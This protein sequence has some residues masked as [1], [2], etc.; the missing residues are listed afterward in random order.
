MIIWVDADAC[1]VPVKE[2]LF[3]AANRLKIDT[4]LV[5]NQYLRTPASQYISA[6]QVPGGFD[7]ADDYIEEQVTAGD[8]VITQDIPLAAKIVELGAVGLNPR[9]TLYDKESVRSHLARRDFMEEM[10]G[11][12]MTTGGPD[13][14]NQQDIAAFA[15]Q[16][17][18]LLTRLLR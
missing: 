2:V 17:D 4:V 12:G 13:P 14:L 15:N 9:G 6:I 8:V 18:R 7:V 3:R 11:A 1:P 16:L 5:A 10:R